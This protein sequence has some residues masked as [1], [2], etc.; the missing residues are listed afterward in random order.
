MEK[1][2]GPVINGVIGRQMR[3]FLHNN[4]QPLG[5]RCMQASYQRHQYGVMFELLLCISFMDKNRIKGGKKVF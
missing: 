4:E 2:L 1:G 5:K 3:I